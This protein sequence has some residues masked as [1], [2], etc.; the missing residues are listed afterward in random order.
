MYLNFSNE[1]QIR[2]FNLNGQPVTSFSKENVQS[3]NCIMTLLHADEVNNRLYVYAGK[4][5][6][7]YDLLK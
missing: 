1:Q 6:S 4:T 5:L 7:V 2:V 3:D